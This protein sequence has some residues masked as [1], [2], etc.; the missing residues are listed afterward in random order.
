MYP[1]QHPGLHR[2]HRPTF[3]GDALHLENVAIACLHHMLLQG[4]PRCQDDVA[5]GPYPQ[6]LPAAEAAGAAL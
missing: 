2:Q 5:G 1:G 6:V 4:I 3:A